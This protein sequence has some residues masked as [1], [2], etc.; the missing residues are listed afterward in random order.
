MVIVQLYYKFHIMPDRMK[1]TIQNVYDTVV[2]QVGDDFVTSILARFSLE[3]WEPV[4]EFPKQVLRMYDLDR[5]TG[6]YE[7]MGMY[8]PST[9]EWIGGAGVLLRPEND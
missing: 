4:T 9:K 7:V 1:M 6:V 3:W 5:R 8:M 2:V